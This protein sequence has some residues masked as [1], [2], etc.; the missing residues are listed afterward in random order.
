MVN[1]PRTLAFLLSLCISVITTLCLWLFKSLSLDGLFITFVAELT[2]SFLLIFAVLDNL[3]FAEVRKLKNL[4]DKLRKKGIHGIGKPKAFTINPLKQ[5]NNEIYTYVDA[6]Q[7]EIDQLRKAEAF[8]KEFIADVSHEL[9]TPIFAAQGFLHTLLDGAIN[10]KN[11]CDKFLRKAA[12]SID[13]LDSLVQNLLTLSQIE[14]GD[15]RM[16]FEDTDLYALTQEVFEQLESKA[17]KKDIRLNVQS[18]IPQVMVYADP[19]RISQ[20]ITNLVANAIKHSTEGDEV[21]VRFH[22]GK[23][24]VTVVVE[25]HGEGIP[26]EHQA[27]IFERFY[28]VDKS[29]SREKGGTGLGLAIVKHI[30]EG[31]DTKATVE[32]EP[33][34]GSRFKFKL[35]KAKTIPASANIK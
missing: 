9:K 7:L 18:E 16:H 32:S 1:S 20:V 33:G 31:H 23:K 2:F 24:K 12:K 17:E 30:L 25:D 27:R 19:V 15:I 35:L 26:A 22:L 29:R 8:R 10:D 6:K 34:K 28:T 3:I 21:S 11:V 13:R 5:I 4:L 14:T